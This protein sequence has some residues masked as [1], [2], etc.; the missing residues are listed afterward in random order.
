MV[1]LKSVK[2]KFDLKEISQVTSV[3]TMYVIFLHY[4]V[5]VIFVG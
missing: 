5:I 2:K 4:F 1:V 3:I